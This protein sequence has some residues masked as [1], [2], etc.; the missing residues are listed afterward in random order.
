ME[1]LPISPDA[2]KTEA[3]PE[4]IASWIDRHSAKAPMLPCRVDEMTEREAE[5]FKVAAYHL[6]FI[7]FLRTALPDQGTDAGQKSYVR[8]E[9]SK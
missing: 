8:E 9:H 5:I 7:Q 3:T 6:G 2:G 4:L 1:R